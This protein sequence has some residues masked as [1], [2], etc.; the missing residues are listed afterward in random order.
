MMKK[1]LSSFGV[2]LF[3]TVMFGQSAL[4][5]VKYTNQTADMRKG[6]AA[7]H[8][9]LL[10][11]YINNKVELD[12]TQ[13]YWDRIWF[14]ETLGWVPSYTLSDSKISEDKLQSDSLQSRMNLMF[15]Q[16]DGDDADVEEELVASPTQVSA[17]VKGFAEKWRRA[18]D[19][20]YTVDFEKFQIEPASPTEFQNFIGVRERKMNPQQERRLLYPDAIFVPY[21][22]P[23]IDQVGYA[24]ASAVAQRGLV[25]NYQLQRY[26]DLLS[27]L[28]VENS[29][30]P[31]LDFKV[32][33][34]D[35]EAVQGYSLPGNYIF[36]SKGA[37]KQMRSEA[38]L[39]HFLAHEIAHL[40][41][42]HGMVEYKE[43]EPRVKRESLLD[44]MRRKLAEEGAE[45][46]ATEEERE[47]EQRITD[48]TDGFYDAANSERLESYE[49]DA[50][51][52]GII[53]TYLSGYNPNEAIKYLNRIQI[54]ET[55]AITEWSGLSLERR[56]EA[57]NE[58]IDD[59]N[60]GSGNT[61]SELFQR[62]MN[63][64]D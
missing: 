50:D 17:A 29:H 26:L 54:S 8:E 60:L 42:S 51:Y 55:E 41:F 40:V 15:S 53:Y 5:Q 52:W 21:T 35:S 3:C 24:V 33:I 61:S 31:E 47:N 19:I 18:R 20:E 43:Q 48:W 39:V 38:E 12:S 58:Q 11:L 9:F 28:I 34:L 56:I 49:F 36:V 16:I 7:Y 32:F 63:S 10:R 1:L 25:S 57:I 64:L 44:E 37:L 4:A 14:K 62:L 59:L 13:G 30:K 23:A 27:G 22:D 45:N 6:P 2:L 46:Q